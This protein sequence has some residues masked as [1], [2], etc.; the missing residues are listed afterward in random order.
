M[1]ELSSSNTFFILCP[2]NPVLQG[3]EELI[4]SRPPICI[5]NNRKSREARFLSGLLSTLGF[6][7]TD[8]VTGPCGPLPSGMSTTGSCLATATET[9]GALPFASVIPVFQSPGLRKHPGVGLDDLLL[10]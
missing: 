3:G 5:L 6:V 1:Y 10:T 7:L 2:R 8:P 4:L 9:F